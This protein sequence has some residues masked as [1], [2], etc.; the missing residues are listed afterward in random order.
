MNTFYVFNA[1][2]IR[3][4][5]DMIQVEKYL[6]ENGWGVTRRMKQADLVIVATCGV[7]KLNEINSLQAVAAAVKKR[8]RNARIVVSGCLPKINPGEINALGDFIMI[9]SGRLDGFDAVI[10]AHKPFCQVGSPDSVTGNKDITNYLMARSYCRRS[11]LYKWLFHRYGM[12]GEFLTASIYAFRMIDLLKNFTA[13][14]RGK[15]FVPY[16]NIKIADGCL[17]NCAF[18][19]TKFATGKLRSRPPESIIGD[20][21]EGLGKNHKIFQL[22]A[23]DTGAYGKDIGIDFSELLRSIFSIDKDYQ[24]VII[25]CCPQ[26]LVEQREVLVPLLAANQEKVKELFIPIQSGSDNVLK[27]MRRNYC[28]ADVGSV[29]KELQDRAPHINLRTSFLVG[30]PGETESDFSETKRF[31]AEMNFSEVTVN[32]YEDRPGTLASTMEDKIPQ[33]IIELRARVLAQELNCSILS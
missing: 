4:A 10:N 18:C 22:I 6:I 3:R 33:E 17:S 23:E 5:L 13:G 20:F 21:Q 25:D 15:K 2:C 16:F 1:G 32:R 31:I 28:T 8:K 24:L 7:V 9:P 19:A 26:W 29:L 14:G 30:F 12:N 27:R 11:R